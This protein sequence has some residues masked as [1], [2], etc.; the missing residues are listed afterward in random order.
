MNPKGYTGYFY[1]YDLNPEGILTR[2][3][4]RLPRYEQN[5]KIII[6]PFEIIDGKF[7]EQ[8]LQR[9]H[10]DYVNTGLTYKQ[11]SKKYPLGSNATLDAYYS[12]KKN[13]TMGIPEYPTYPNYMW[14][15]Q[16]VYHKQL[17][18]FCF[19]CSYQ[20]LQALFDI[21]ITEDD[22]ER[23]S[24]D[25]HS[26]I[27]CPDPVI[28]MNT[29][30]QLYSFLKKTLP[31]A[32]F[33]FDVYQLSIAIDTAAKAMPAK[34]RKALYNLKADVREQLNLFFANSCSQYHKNYILNILSSFEDMELPLE[35]AEKR[36]IFFRR[37]YSIMENNPSFIENYFSE[38]CFHQS[39]PQ[40]LIV[41]YQ[42]VI[43]KPG[44]F[45]VERLA[46]MMLSMMKTMPSGKK[47]NSFYILDNQQVDTMHGIS[48][49]KILSSGL[50]GSITPC[51]TLELLKE[52]MKKF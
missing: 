24:V 20:D 31:G 33:C 39:L 9:L 47:L 52:E 43:A 49:S 2:V 3:G 27:D 17:I 23:F 38:K 36:N 32:T 28:C 7:G 15:V 29:D 50:S 42:R 22:F 8:A 41:E 11:F 12:L 46:Y 1:R 44:G 14:F 21:L 16:T 26:K 40:E 25:I 35:A 30:P 19:S 51:N 13:Y 45:R 48:L 37:L 6:E 4:M 5:G 34:S 10:E 18:T